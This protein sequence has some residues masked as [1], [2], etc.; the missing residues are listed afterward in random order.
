[1][2]V[3]LNIT[4]YPMLILLIV[5]TAVFVAPRLAKMQNAVTQSLLNQ[6]EKYSRSLQEKIDRDFPPETLPNEL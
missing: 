1:M 4:T 5:E 2:R 6:D 3:L